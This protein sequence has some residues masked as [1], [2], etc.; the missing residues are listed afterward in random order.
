GIVKD[1][2]PA[3][4]SAID[5]ALRLSEVVIISGGTSAGAGDLAP[6]IADGM[7]KP[8]LVFHGLAMKPGKPAFA[9]VVRGKPIFGLPGYP[10]SALMVFHQLVAGYIME[11]S[12]L[13][14]RGG[15]AMQAKLAE[16]VILA[17][18]RREL[19]PVRLTGKAGAMVA[20]PVLKGSGAVTSLLLADGYI[21]A[22]A[23]REFIPEG[24]TVRVNLF[25]GWKGD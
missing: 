22:A 1:S 10:V 3:I 17:R 14:G 20:K 25:G 18:G 23:E 5:K 13:S 6:K 24:E 4:K 7:G 12:G 15:P 21:D 9:A 2:A 19:I 16:K 8:G 11:L